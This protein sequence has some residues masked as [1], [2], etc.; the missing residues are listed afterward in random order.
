LIKKARKEDLQE[1]LEFKEEAVSPEL[2]FVY[3][4]KSYGANLNLQ[5]RI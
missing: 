2:Q 4:E 5:E 1:I 3:L